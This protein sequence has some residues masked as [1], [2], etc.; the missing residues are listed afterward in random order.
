MSGCCSQT[1][2]NAN[3]HSASA[4]QGIHLPAGI[5]DAAVTSSPSWSATTRRRRPRASSHRRRFRPATTSRCAHAPHQPGRPTQLLLGD[6]DQHIAAFNAVTVLDE[7]LPARNPGIRRPDLSPKQRE[8]REP[9]RA[10]RGPR[11][12]VRVSM[13]TMQA[14]LQLLETRLSRPVR[15]AAVASPS[16]SAPAGAPLPDRRTAEP[17]RRLPTRDVRSSRGRV[18]GGSAGPCS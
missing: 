2:E 18:Q 13:E 3:V 5:D 9:G 17:G 12:V 16:R 11:L 15:N 4:A 7:P 1:R 6:G 8:Q 10:S 14:F